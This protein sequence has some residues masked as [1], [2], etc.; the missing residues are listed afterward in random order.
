[1]KKFSILVALLA[2]TLFITPTVLG[3]TVLKVGATPMPHAE[4]LEHISPILAQSGIKLEIIEF[5]DYIRPNRALYEKE[6]DANF[7]QHTPYLETFNQDAGTNLMPSIGV[8]I[9]PLGL[10]SY[11]VK[12]VTE[13]PERAEIAIPNDATNGGRALLLLQEAGLI[14]INPNVKGIPTVFDITENKLRLKIHELEAPQLTRA[15]PDVHAAIIN[16][17]YA[18]EANLHPVTDSIWLEGSESQYVNIL[19][20]RQDNAQDPAIL[21]LAEVL[22]SDVVRDFI[23]DHFDGS[24]IAV[25]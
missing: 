13:I 20:I 8:F 6:I 12:S 11:K 5:T 23:N 19:A 22:V 10:Y 17:T 3:Q 7:F 15:L 2:L 9:A 18:L 25:F 14:T 21:K 4:I 24:I 1:M 16:V